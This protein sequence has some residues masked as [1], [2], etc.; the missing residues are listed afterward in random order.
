MT[1]L[2][3]ADPTS[4]EVAGQPEGRDALFTSDLYRVG[5]IVSVDTLPGSYQPQRTPPLQAYGRGSALRRRSR[6]RAQDRSP[7]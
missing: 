1:P 4:R 7:E 3:G 2:R 6:S 5:E